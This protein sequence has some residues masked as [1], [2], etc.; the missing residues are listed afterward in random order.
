MSS[1]ELLPWP[2]FFCLPLPLLTTLV[3][4]WTCWGI[5]DNFPIV[6]SA[7]EYVHSTWNFHFPLTC[8]LSQIPQIWTWTS[9][10]GGMGR[11]WRQHYSTLYPQGHLMVLYT[12]YNFYCHVRFP[13]SRKEEMGKDEKTHLPAKLVPTQISANLS[14]A[15]TYSYGY[16]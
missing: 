6:R 11:R 16:I 3:I 15:G 7:D 9:L 8:H 4:I 10:V 1:W 13:G 14:L 12:Y 5:Q 2:V